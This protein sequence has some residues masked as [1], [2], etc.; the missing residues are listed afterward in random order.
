MT[1]AWPESCP[2]QTG[3]SAAAPGRW[4]Y[5]HTPLSLKDEL[6][7]RTGREI[8]LVLTDNRRRMASVRRRSAGVYEVRLQKLF[9]DSPPEVL[10]ELAAMVTGKNQDRR[11]VRAFVDARLADGDPL[12]VRKKAL[13]AGD[14]RGQGQCHDLA[15]YARELNSLYLN[16]RSTA[17]IVW[18]RKNKKRGLRSI[19]FACY[20]ITRNMIIMNRKMDS[21]AIPRYF[22]EF[23]LFH[24]MLHEVLGVGERADGR[25]DIHGKVFKLMETTFPDYDKALRFEK[26]LCTRLATL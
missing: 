13:P 2:T 16:N 14:K 24:E 10:D 18:G 23:I 5:Q 9:L 22:V 11:A 25:R 17:A 20:D 8:L 15:A 19:R 21:P 6:T 4:L 1:A 12:V 26:E 3:S 7:R